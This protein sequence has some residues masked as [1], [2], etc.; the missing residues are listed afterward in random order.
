MK[1]RTAVA[2]FALFQVL[3]I[4]TTNAPAQETTDPA[5]RIVTK[6]VPQY[7]TVARSLHLQGNV[8]ADVLV[9]ADGKVKSVDV[10]GGHPVLVLSAEQALRQWKWEPASH[11]THQ[12]VE[13]KF[14]P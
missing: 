13:L 12:I 8:R 10:M 4:V 1:S 7:P 2:L 3:L 11:D 6:V 5:R 9:A 14:T